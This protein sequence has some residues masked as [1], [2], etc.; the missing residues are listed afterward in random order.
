M[1]I[2]STL[3][4]ISRNWCCKLFSARTFLFWVLNE[5]SF[6]LNGSPTLVLS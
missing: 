6:L 5:F 2:S 1:G 3:M 4:G